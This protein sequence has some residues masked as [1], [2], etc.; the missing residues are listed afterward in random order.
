MLRKP[1]A[2][3]IK[4]KKRVRQLLSSIWLLD[5]ALENRLYHNFHSVTMT[6]NGETAIPLRREGLATQSTSA[7]VKLEVRMGK[8]S[9]TLRRARPVPLGRLSLGMKKPKHCIDP[10]SPVLWRQIDPD[11]PFDGT[12]PLFHFPP[13][14]LMKSPERAH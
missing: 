7:R 11:Q 13:H 3:T 10:S 4:R 8:N 2:S 5:G 12:V 6:Q 14:V 9:A 1:S